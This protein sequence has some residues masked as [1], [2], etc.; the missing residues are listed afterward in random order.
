[1]L[2]TFVFISLIYFLFRLFISDKFSNRKEV[3]I[4]K[5]VFLFIYLIIIIGLQIVETNKYITKFCNRESLDKAILYTLVP[6]LLIFGFLIMILIA[7]PG[8]KAPFSNT[9][10][11]VAASASGIKKHFDTL[12]K[13]DINNDLMKKIIQDKSLIVNEITPGNFELFLAQLYSNGLLA[14]DYEELANI[15]SKEKAGTSL[16]NKEQI[17]LDAYS[18]LYKAVV[19]KDLIAEGLWYLLTGALVITMTKNAVAELECEKSTSQMKKEYKKAGSG[20]SAMENI[21]E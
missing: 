12:L 3:N 13:S 17:Y 19:I 6:N 4:T 18:G 21:K 2:G 9:L 15:E 16:T 11:Y 10:G 14:I 5:W 7:F 8:W 20:V 1:M